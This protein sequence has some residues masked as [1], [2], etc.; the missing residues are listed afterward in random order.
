MMMQEKGCQLSPLYEDVY[1]MRMQ[2][3]MEDNDILYWKKIQE[4]KSMAQGHD[5]IALLFVLQEL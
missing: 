3:T 1:K 4:M 2:V 5:V